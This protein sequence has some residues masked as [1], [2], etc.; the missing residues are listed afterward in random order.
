MLSELDAL[1]LIT[2]LV[3][4]DRQATEEEL[5]RIVAH[6]AEAP[7]SSRP[8]RVPRRIRERLAQAACSPVASRLPSLELHLLERVHAD[9]QWLVGTTA[10]RYLDDLHRAV[11]HPAAQIWTYRHYGEPTIAFLSPSSETGG[12]RR[13]PWLFVAYRPRY[14]TIVTGYQVS[15]AE[16]VLG[17]QCEKLRRQR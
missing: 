14:G 10:A 17:K 12:P 1:A 8:V 11:Q 3:E 9:K 13:L 4:Q 5:A 15:G 2:E 16:T 7:F 6:V